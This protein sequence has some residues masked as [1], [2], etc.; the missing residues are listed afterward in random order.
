MLFLWRLVLL[1]CR[2][3]FV[4]FERLQWFAEMLVL[5]LRARF[6]FDGTTPFEG[7]IARSCHEN[8]SG[9]VATTAAQQIA[10]IDTFRCFIAWSSGCTNRTWDFK[11]RY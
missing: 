3:E 2:I 11:K 9:V 6:A 1:F 7:A 4:E 5:P 10:S 8:S